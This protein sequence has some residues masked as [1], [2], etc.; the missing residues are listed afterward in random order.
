[1]RRETYLYTCGL[2]LQLGST[3]KI[4]L[5]MLVQYNVGI[6]MEGTCQ[7]A[8]GHLTLTSFLS[9]TDSVRFTSSFH[10]QISFS[11]T[12]HHKLTIF[13]PQIDHSRRLRPSDI[14]LADLQP[15]M[16]NLCTNMVSLCCIR[17]VSSLSYN[18]GSP[19]LVHRLTIVGQGHVTYAW[20]TYSPQFSTC[21]PNMVS[22]CCIR[23]V[24]L[25]IIQHRITMFG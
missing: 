22:L 20:M 23:S 12:I 3:G 1:M 19:Y 11:F 25:F 2:L 18:I 8:T 4:Q 17:S 13:G 24:S 5:N 9:S 6:I 16:V 15:G 14:C 10:D 21:G 7:P